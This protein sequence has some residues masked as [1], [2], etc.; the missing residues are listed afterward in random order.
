[1]IQYYD[2]L[3]HLEVSKRVDSIKNELAI[4]TYADVLSEMQQEYGVY[5]ETMS[6]PHKFDFFLVGFHL[7]GSATIKVN[8]V[9]YEL[10][11][12]SQH[13]IKL[14]P[15]Q[16]VSIDKVSE[17]FNAHVVLMSKRFIESLLVYINGSIPLR[18]DK[19]MTSVVECNETHAEQII[20]VFK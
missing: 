6:A 3:P 5:V 18:I 12:D 8:M 17:D 15:G 11:A 16:I 2:W 14:A 7:S 4:F 20:N 9:E 10:S 1:M 13:I 19:N